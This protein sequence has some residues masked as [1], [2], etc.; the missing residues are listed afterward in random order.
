MSRFDQRPFHTREQVELKAVGE[1]MMSFHYFS[2]HDRSFFYGQSGRTPKAGLVLL[3][4]G[5]AETR[6]CLYL[7]MICSLSRLFNRSIMSN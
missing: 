1:Q 6:S 7:S 3:G 5:G 4:W 2:H